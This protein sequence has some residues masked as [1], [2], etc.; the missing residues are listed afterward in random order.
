MANSLATNPIFIDTGHLTTPQYTRNL[1]PSSLSVR[2]ASAG[3]INLTIYN[4][5]T[6][7]V[8]KVA[9]P[10]N[11]TI[12]VPGVGKMQGL[13]VLRRPVVGTDGVNTTVTLTIFER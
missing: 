10:A 12:S 9:V 8:F 13:H 2:N 3:A 5:D 1:Y 4:R 7:V 6:E 11:N